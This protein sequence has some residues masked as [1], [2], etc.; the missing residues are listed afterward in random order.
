M[1]NATDERT[2]ENPVSI[3]ADCSDADGDV[4]ECVKCNCALFLRDEMEWLGNDT[5]LMCWECQH[6]FIV[7]LAIMVRR[8]S[9]SLTKHDSEHPLPL[10]ALDYLRRTHLQ[11]SPL[12]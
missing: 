11:D 2:A 3:D 6:D 5:P 1:S 8:L 9:A 7:N 4:R 12:R 10:K